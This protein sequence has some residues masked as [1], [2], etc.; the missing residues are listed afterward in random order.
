MDR[1]EEALTALRPLFTGLGAKR[2]LVHAIFESNKYFW[3]TG[4]GKMKSNGKKQAALAEG[5]SPDDVVMEAMRRTITGDRPW[6]R[7]KYPNILNHLKWVITSLVANLAS[8][9]DNKTFRAMPEDEDG[10]QREAGLP[11]AAE[12]PEPEFEAPTD[13]ADAPVERPPE[14][15]F[16]RGIVG[17]DADALANDIFD[18]ISDDPQLLAV[19][20][21]MMSDKKPRDI[22][23]AMGL[24]REDVYK[25]TQKLRRRLAPVLGVKA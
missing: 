6:N 17:P 24:P 3:R 12:T 2:L 13:E 16:L 7:T 21:Q 23:A 4:S 11:Q 9:A 14:V 22:V 8:S 20:E 15:A 19:F 25:L 10:N 18:A 1:Q 5:M